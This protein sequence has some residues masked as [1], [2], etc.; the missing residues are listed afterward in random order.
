MGLFSRGKEKQLEQA[1]I[2]LTETVKE[3]IISYTKKWYVGPHTGDVQVHINEGI[4]HMSTEYDVSGGA[5]FLSGYAAA[6]YK[7]LTHMLVMTPPIEEILPAG[8]AGQRLR[9][10]RCKIPI[11]ENG[12]LSEL[13]E[14]FEELTRQVKAAPNLSVL[15]KDACNTCEPPRFPITGGGTVPASHANIFPGQYTKGVESL[16]EHQFQAREEINRAL[17]EVPSYLT[18]LAEREAQRQAE[19]GKQARGGRS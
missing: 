18:R 10:V 15:S 3:Y 5:E 1:R 17:G 13:Q 11:G 12:G 19:S 7:N 14:L 16:A 9:G 6:P 8:K 4:L 2:E